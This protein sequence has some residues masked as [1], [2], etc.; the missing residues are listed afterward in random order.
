M[1]WTTL[2]LRPTWRPHQAT[3]SRSPPPYS[4]WTAQALLTANSCP[5]P[6]SVH[7]MCFISTCNKP[8]YCFYLV[9]CFPGSA[10]LPCS[11]CSRPAQPFAPQVLRVQQ[12][13]ILP[14]GL[15]RGL[16]AGQSVLQCP[17]HRAAPHHHP[18]QRALHP[19]AALRERQPQPGGDPPPLQPAAL[20]AMLPERR[21]PVCRRQRRLCRI[22]FTGGARESHEAAA[23][24]LLAADLGARHTESQSIAWW[25]YSTCN[26][27]PLP[28]T[29][30][31]CPT[32]LAA[33]TSRTPSLASLS[34][35][36][37]YPTNLTSGPGMVPSSAV[38][39]NRA[40]RSLPRRHFALPRGSAGLQY[41]LGHEPCPDVCDAAVISSVARTDASTGRLA[42]TFPL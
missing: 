33:W 2:P 28:V 15:T 38:I 14:Q 13:H 29:S 25:R 16:D 17:R 3:S 5:S 31:C 20:Q 6:S 30:F 34:R 1:W 35:R 7:Q 39:L 27:V 18:V 24:V 9:Q 42:S 40:V 26:F 22:G 8:M 19:S 12:P 37:S 23:K 11:I 4:S 41:M 21:H 10:S 36:A 32:I